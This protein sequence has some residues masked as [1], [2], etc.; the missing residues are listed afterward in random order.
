M[1]ALAPAPIP[2]NIIREYRLLSPSL[3]EVA[4]VAITL[5]T[6]LPSSAE[7]L[8]TTEGRYKTCSRSGERTTRQDPSSNNRQTSWPFDTVKTHLQSFNNDMSTGMD[9]L[10]KTQKLVLRGSDEHAERAWRILS[11]KTFAS[12]ALNQE[13]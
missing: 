12:S 11:A 4:A 9:C 5:P 6:A 1:F 8:S 2:E 13:C 3:P 7:T 10:S